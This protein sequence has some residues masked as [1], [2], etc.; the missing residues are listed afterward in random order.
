MNPPYWEDGAGRPSPH[1]LA[2]RARSACHGLAAFLAAARSLLVYHGRLFCIFPAVRLVYLAESV[3]KYGFGLRRLQ[4]VR[5]YVDARA[6]RVMA[7]AM[8]DA[9]HETAIEPDLVLY[10]RTLSGQAKPKEEA[11]SF[12]PWVR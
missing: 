1:T 9:D 8:K 3:K 6:G 5:P 10:E 4:F 7:E 12:C 11:L 2:N